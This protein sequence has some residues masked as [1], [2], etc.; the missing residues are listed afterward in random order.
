M[1][2]KDDSSI[3]PVTATDRDN[4]QLVGEGCIGLGF[5][6]F[7]GAAKVN[8]FKII[9]Y[10]CYYFSNIIIMMIIISIISTILIL[11]LILILIIVM[12]FFGGGGC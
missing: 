10:Y 1:H 4:E 8:Y 6:V 12:F 9:N 5:R 11:I 2:W 7:S 3:D